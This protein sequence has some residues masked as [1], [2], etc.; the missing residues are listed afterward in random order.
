MAG[1]WL[2]VTCAG[3]WEALGGPHW[4]CR[5]GMLF[6]L[7]RRREHGDAV[8]RTKRRLTGQRERQC[9]N[10]DIS[11]HGMAVQ[12]TFGRQRVS[13]QG[14]QWLCVCGWQPC[15]CWSHEARIASPDRPRVYGCLVY[16]YARDMRP[17]TVTTRRTGYRQKHTGTF[18]VALLLLHPGASFF[19]SM[20]ELRGLAP[21]L[22]R[23]QSNPI[24]P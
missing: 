16:T 22:R 3:G 20:V 8:A 11:S 13:G 23:W 17:F 9:I 14:G 19:F 2:P 12:S 24:R 6:G 1:F 5:G 21:H 15:L 18:T 7:A 4:E 10:H